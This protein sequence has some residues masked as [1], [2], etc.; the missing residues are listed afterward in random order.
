MLCF[1]ERGVSELVA[2]L[3]NSC[4]YNW[5][6]V[7]RVCVCQRKGEWGW[8]LGWKAEMGDASREIG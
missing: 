4:V 7:S 6:R 3:G 2:A 8:V 5:G 1:W